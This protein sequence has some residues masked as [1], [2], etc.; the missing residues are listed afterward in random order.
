ME[1]LPLWGSWLLFWYY[2]K[3]PKSMTI[4][5]FCTFFPTDLIK[6]EARILVIVVKWHHRANGLLQ[7]GAQKCDHFWFI[8]ILS[9]RFNPIRSQL[10]TVLHIWL[11]NVCMK[12]CELI[13]GG[14]T[15]GLL[16]VSKISNSIKQHFVVKVWL[17]SVE[18]SVSSTSACK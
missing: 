1:L 9:Y 4:F 14:R 17:S 11:V 18:K 2:S 3:E 10:E 6:S 8:H 15:I 13:K 5:Y 16:A 7:Q 12:E